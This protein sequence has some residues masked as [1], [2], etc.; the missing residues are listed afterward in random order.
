MGGAN[1]AL[2]VAA[3]LVL[4]VTP[5][6]DML[7]VIARGIA[8]GR[9]VAVLTS[10]GISTGLLV[11]TTLAALGLSVLLK[12]SL[13]AFLVVKYLGAGYLLYLGIRALRAREAIRLQAD[14]GPVSPATALRQ[15][16][17][18]NLLNPKAALFVQAFLPQFVVRDSAN[19]AVQILAL[20]LVLIALGLAF[21]ILVACTAEYLGTW[22]RR[23]PLINA[24]LRWLTGSVFIGLGLR[25]A[26]P[27]R[28]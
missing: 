21:H 6:P 17:L 26:L 7:F 22:L 24:R 1:L 9:L 27:E 16:L 10:L 3:S 11:H 5:G 20:G 23:Q 4:I 28:C 13:V 15:G 19:P 18:S 2:F 14:W 8:Q 12:Q 25:L